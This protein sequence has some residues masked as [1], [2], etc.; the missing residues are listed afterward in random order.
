LKSSGHQDRPAHDQPD[1]APVI[2]PGPRPAKA[3]IGEDRAN[4]LDVALSG[5]NDGTALNREPRND[6][7][8]ELPATVGMTLDTALN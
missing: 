6:S 8:A 2:A 3:A 1:R 7:R 4:T 5:G